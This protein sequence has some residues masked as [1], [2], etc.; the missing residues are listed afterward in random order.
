MLTKRAHEFIEDWH[1]AF[2]DEG[3]LFTYE[4]WSEISVKTALDLAL[5]EANVM[6]KE[7]PVLRDAEL[8]LADATGEDFHEIGELI[9]DI[10]H[11]RKKRLAYYLGESKTIVIK[12]G[13]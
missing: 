3:E 5:Y 8:A 7:W 2:N 13:T 12:G 6:G 9:A 1:R 10:L 4:G 11:N